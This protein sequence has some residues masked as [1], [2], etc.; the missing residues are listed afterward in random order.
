[1]VAVAVVSGGASNE[2]EEGRGP[3]AEEEAR[4]Q[5]TED[6]AAVTEGTV[7]ARAEELELVAE[8]VVEV[9]AEAG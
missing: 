4:R 8:E 6:M 2:G 5:A 1:M 9:M 7:V 3:Q